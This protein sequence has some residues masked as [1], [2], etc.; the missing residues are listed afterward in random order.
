MMGARIASDYRALLLSCTIERSTLVVSFIYT[1]SIKRSCHSYPNTTE[2]GDVGWLGDAYL[3]CYT[4]KM[5]PIFEF[6]C[7]RRWWRFQSLT[8]SCTN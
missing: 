2:L 4:Q 1:S 6:V 8:S 3:F 7:L 5:F